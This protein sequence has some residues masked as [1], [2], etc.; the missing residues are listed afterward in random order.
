MLF[1]SGLPAGVQFRAYDMNMV[2]LDGAEVAPE[3]AAGREKTNEV[4]VNVWGYGPGWSVEMFENGKA[5]SVERQRA[6]DPLFLLSCPIPYM[7]AG[8]KL[9]GTVRPVYTM[10]LFTAKASAADT[11][12]EIRV[13][14]R[15]G[16]V[17]SSVVKRPQ[18]M[19]LSMH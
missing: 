15:C 10:H 2:E 7:A 12:V 8:N 19:S 1:R 13:A 14:D 3:Y 16:N 11:P 4:M 17:Y 18:P 6:R 5:L 9:I